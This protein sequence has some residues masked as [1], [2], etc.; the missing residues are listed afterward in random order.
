MKL[1]KKE[2]QKVNISVFSEGRTKYSWEEIQGQ[3]EEQGLKKRSSRNCLTIPY[4]TTKPKHDC[5]CQ[6]VLA[7]RNLIGM[8]QVYFFTQASQTTR[9]GCYKF[10]VSVALFWPLIVILAYE[11]KVEVGGL[12]SECV[13]IIPPTYSCE[14]IHSRFSKKPESEAWIYKLKRWGHAQKLTF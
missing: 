14:H 7:D 4:A 3:R 6:E 10:M 8:S 11:Y 9:Y 1:K 12:K 5:W 2:G 13:Y